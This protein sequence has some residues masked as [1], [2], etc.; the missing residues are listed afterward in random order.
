MNVEK[1]MQKQMVGTGIKARREPKK[2]NRSRLLSIQY[3]VEEFCQPIIQE[4]SNLRNIPIV[5]NE[6]C[7]SWY[8]YPLMKGNQTSCYF[9]ST[10]GHN[11]SWN[12]SLKR[13][14][15]NIIRI[16]S[17]Q[18]TCAIL[19]ASASKI[20]PDSFARTIPI[21][22]AVMNRI[23]IRYRQLYDIPPCPHDEM[24]DH[25]LLFTPENVVTNDE[26]ETMLNLI[27]T[28]VEILFQSQAIVDPKWLAT[29]LQKPIRPYWISPHSTSSISGTFTFFSEMFYSIVCIN[30]SDYQKYHSITKSSIQQNEESFLYIPG[31]ADDHESWGRHLTPQLFWD[32]IH[33]ILDSTISPSYSLDVVID[34]I[35]QRE[36]QENEEFEKSCAGVVMDENN[37]HRIG[38]LN[39]FIGTRR[40]GRPPICWKYFDAI[41]NVTDTEYPEMRENL[42]QESNDVQTH[43]M[44]NDPTSKTCRKWYL[45]LPVREGKRDRTELE[46]WMALGI[47]FI[48]VHARQGCKVLI[49]CAQGMDRSVAVVIAV[50][51][52][53]CDYQYPL[54]WNDCYWRF[55]VN[56]FVYES[57]D[58]SQCSA[59]GLSS[60]VL[61]TML[62]RGGRDKLLAFIYTR[63][64][65]RCI[66][67]ESI[68]IVLQLVQ[69]YREKANPSRTTIQ[70]VHRFFMSSEAVDDT[71]AKVRLGL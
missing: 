61:H 65:K 17:T 52:I 24:C 26:H 39:I 71:Y 66:T 27:E 18:G 20:M 13:L 29:T 32:N 22:A 42:S 30:C 47:I 53:F 44:T 45:Q 38:L 58:K 70:K 36:M 21:W 25:D 34:S 68:R 8:A 7:G 10:D 49:H 46:N 12:F 1:V 35:V 19:D 55:P 16:L 43:I 63:E 14:N 51:A 62:G 67:K 59:S 60:D 2:R 64:S 54:Q 56:E 9:K 31:A 6:R 5:A 15:L 11:G 4:M 23:A 28:R 33:T 3:D 40:A 50:V 57:S 41:L 48:I 69:Q 37:F